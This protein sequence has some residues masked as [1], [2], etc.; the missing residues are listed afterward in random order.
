MYHPHTEKTYKLRHHEMFV[1]TL[2]QTSS[3]S[4][5]DE[6]S[7]L[8]LSSDSECIVFC[9]LALLVDTMLAGE[10]ITYTSAMLRTVLS[11]R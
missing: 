4:A 11:W 3:D 8:W 2:W 10:V 1:L 6:L 9:R 7:S 5:P